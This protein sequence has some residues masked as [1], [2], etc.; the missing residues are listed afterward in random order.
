MHNLKNY[1]P[2]LNL[3]QAWLFMGLLMSMLYVGPN[4]KADDAAAL[5]RLQNW[6]GISQAAQADFAFGNRGRGRGLIAGRDFAQGE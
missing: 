2:R 6:L 5:S 4:A 3:R 1:I